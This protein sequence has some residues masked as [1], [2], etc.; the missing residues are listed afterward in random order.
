MTTAKQCVCSARLQ[1]TW[2]QDVEEALQGSRVPLEDAAHIINTTSSALS[3]NTDETG[4]SWSF[5]RLHY[6]TWKE[7]QEGN[8]VNGVVDSK[9]QPLGHIWRSHHQWS[10]NGGANQSFPSARWVRWTLNFEASMFNTPEVLCWPNLKLFLPLFPK[11]WHFCKHRSSPLSRPPI[12]ATLHG[13]PAHQ[14]PG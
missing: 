3:Q 4:L 7:L 8:Y 9:N 11:V 10:C 5:A 12:S 1:Q 6:T 14:G 2:C 13:Q